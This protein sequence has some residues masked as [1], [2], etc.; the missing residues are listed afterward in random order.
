MES[1]TRY[2]P[3]LPSEEKDLADKST[4]FCRGEMLVF[5]ASP[6]KY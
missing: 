1:D 3:P 2:S 5:D 4:L 6:D